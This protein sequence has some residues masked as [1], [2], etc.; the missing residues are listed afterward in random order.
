MGDR[1]ELGND[2]FIQP[3]R[4]LS[5]EIVELDE[6]IYKFDLAVHGIEYPNSDVA[7]VITEKEIGQRIIFDPTNSILFYNQF[8][9]IDFAT[10]SGFHFNNSEI[11]RHGILQYIC[12]NLGSDIKDIKSGAFVLPAFL[13][14]LLI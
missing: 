5:Y 9:T 4:V 11:I 10:I 8:Y 6:P 2:L 7:L 1:R 14:D 3:L 12:H 13:S